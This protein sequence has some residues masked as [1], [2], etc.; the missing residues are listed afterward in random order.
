MNDIQPLVSVVMPVYNTEKYVGAAID[1]ILEQTFTAFECIV[2]DDGSTDGSWS[3]I[4][5]YAKKD[6]RIIA[7]Q[8][9]EN[10]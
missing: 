1:S 3:I 4:Q 2:I 9:T 7:S 5:Q 6:P 10:R 8:N